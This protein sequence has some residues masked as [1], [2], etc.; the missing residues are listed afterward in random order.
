[1][2]SANDVLIAAAPETAPL[3]MT[4]EER[5]SGN[6][7]NV[8]KETDNNNVLTLQSSL[9]EHA[10]ITLNQSGVGI[11]RTGQLLE[12]SSD[13][14]NLFTEQSHLLLSSGGYDLS[15]TGSG[16]VRTNNVLV[17]QITDSD[18]DQNYTAS[19][20]HNSQGEPDAFPDTVTVIPADIAENEYAQGRFRWRN[21]EEVNEDIKVY[22]YPWQHQGTEVD[23]TKDLI[24]CTR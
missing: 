9:K 2:T 7:T 18:G 5:M 6:F 16:T 8:S 19:G 3:D 13:N 1:M 21:S 22:T 20:S 23:L 4:L 15:T 12:L 17:L 10:F 24:Y 14:A 11:M